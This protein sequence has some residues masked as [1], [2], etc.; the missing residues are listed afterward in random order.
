MSTFDDMMKTAYGAIGTKYW[1]GGTD[2]RPGGKG[3]DC[4]SFVQQVFASVGIQLPRVSNDQA[5]SGTAVSRDQMQPGDLIWWDLNGRNDGADHIGIYIGNGQVIE[6]APSADG[7]KVRKLWG[8]YNVTRVSGTP[9]GEA[10]APA[11][12][13]GVAGGDTV[14][15]SGR[16]LMGTLD[17]N[18]LN[19]SMSAS[20]FDVSKL[21]ELADMDDNQGETRESVD[22]FTVARQMIDRFNRADDDQPGLGGDKQFMPRRVTPSRTS[23]L[24]N[25]KQSMPQRRK[26]KTLGNDKQA[27]PQRKTKT[28]GNDKQDMPQQP[29]GGW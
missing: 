10:G 27:M 23:T 20:G 5:R 2:M 7:V 17:S 6:S 19:A 21:Y 26:T 13:A 1:F 24:G 28:L 15:Q 9:T 11:A 8:N 29:G 12:A 4:S 14:R 22:P 16:S 18:V 3:I 25:D